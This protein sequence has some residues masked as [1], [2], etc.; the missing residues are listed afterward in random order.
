MIAG[1]G[2]IGLKWALSEKIGAE[3]EVEYLPRILP[4][5]DDEI[6]KMQKIL[7]KWC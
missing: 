6:A 2:I 1:V 4:G 3:V 5:I 7:Q